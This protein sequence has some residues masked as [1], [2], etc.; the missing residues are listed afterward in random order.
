VVKTSICTVFCS[1]LNQQFFDESKDHVDIINVDFKNPEAAG[2]T[3]TTWAKRK[4]KNGLKINDISVSPSTK[5]ALTSAVYYKANWIY[6]FNP[7]QPGLFYAPQGPIQVP[8]MNIKR[9]YR[10]GKIGDIAEWA[11]IP[12]ESED[13]LIIILPNKD[14]TL[15]RLIQAMNEQVLVDVL[16]DFDRDSSNVGEL[17]FVLVLM[18]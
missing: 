6:R 3:I 18:I 17:N 13:S 5:I 1:R 7:A 4:T 15:D 16:Y 12:Y 11:A 10:W 14:Q 8:M 2:R 9:K